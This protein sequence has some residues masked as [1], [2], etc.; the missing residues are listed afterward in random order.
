[1]S[2]DNAQGTTPTSTEA[3]EAV[4]LTELVAVRT[5]DGQDLTVGRGHALASED[6]TIVEGDPDAGSDQVRTDLQELV[7]ARTADGTVITVGRGHAEASEDL[8]VLSDAYDDMTVAQLDDEIARRNA[9]RPDEAKVNPKGN[10]AAKVA[11]LDTDDTI[12]PA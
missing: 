4:D 9:D 12:H 2:D 11:A 6:L 8:T 10:K 7:A 1:M 3:E 5:V